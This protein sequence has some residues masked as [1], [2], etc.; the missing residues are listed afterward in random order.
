MPTDHQQ[1]AMTPGAGCDRRA[2][3]C[4]HRF[5]VM[6]CIAAQVALAYDS[7]TPM[8]P[9]PVHAKPWVEVTQPGVQTVLLWKFNS[10]EDR[11]ADVEAMLEGDD[12]A[13][14]DAPADGPGLLDGMAGEAERAEPVLRGGAKVVAGAGRFGGGLVLAGASAAAAAN[15]ALRS[16]LIHDMGLTLD[17][18]IRPDTEPADGATECLVAIPDALGKDALSVRRDGNGQVAVFW[19]GE[20]K[21]AH[22]RTVPV[23]QWSH[24]SLVITT[25]G[26]PTGVSVDLVMV[27][28]NLQLGVNGHFVGV[29]RPAWLNGGSGG[30]VEARTRC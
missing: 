25:S 20:K 16:V 24:I 26:A 18:W 4:I 28:S 27:W 7:T 19:R 17:L 9:V 30:P 22:P 6:L 10:D 2:Q 21:L 1:L 13:V 8:A 14:D 11:D 12:L 5:L 29:G 23:G 3:P 15:V